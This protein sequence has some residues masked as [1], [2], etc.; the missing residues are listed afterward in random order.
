MLLRGIEN[1]ENMQQMWRQVGEMIDAKFT[2]D[3]GPK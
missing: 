3:E 2:L 1:T